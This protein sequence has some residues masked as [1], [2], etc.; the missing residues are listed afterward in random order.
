MKKINYSLF[1]SF[2]ATIIFLSSCKKKEVEVVT[3]APTISF[4]NGQGMTT[5]TKTVI[6]DEEFSVG[7]N[8]GAGGAN[9]STL[10]IDRNGAA[11]NEFNGG[12]LTKTI[13]GSSYSET[14]KI[15]APSAPETYT[16]NFKVTTADN[17]TASTSLVI[18][19]KKQIGNAISSYTGIMLGAPTNG[20]KGGFFSSSNQMVYSA[21]DAKANSSSVDLIYVISNND[22]IFV[23]PSDIIAQQAY[24]GV[25]D[26]SSR[27]ATSFQPTTMT[28][29]EFDKITGDPEIVIAFDGASGFAKANTSNL[30]VGTVIAFKTKMEKKGVI[31]ITNI[32]TG[33]NGT[34]TFDVKVQ[35]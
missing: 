9:L 27:N 23:A 30:A 2:L 1:L 18:I 14:L 16:Y 35:K 3:P 26:W 21:A 32:T 7:V 4:I 29:A 13:S 15:K 6:P 31:K 34:I 33:I 22:Y 8:L 17:K 24:A 12:K 11:I 20:S 5:V 25:S 10:S 19:V 28:A